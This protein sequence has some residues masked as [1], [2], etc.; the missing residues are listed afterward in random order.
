MRK[1]LGQ[2]KD[3]SKIRKYSVK[4][5]FEKFREKD[6]KKDFPNI[7]LVVSEF[8]TNFLMEMRGL[9]T[10]S[11]LNESDFGRLASKTDN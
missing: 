8:S 10:Y 9:F 5:R 7:Y 1:S 11:P 2:A 3:Q 4:F 6:V